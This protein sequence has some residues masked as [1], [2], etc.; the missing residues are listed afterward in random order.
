ML[1]AAARARLAET[2]TAAIV[3]AGARTSREAAFGRRVAGV[4]DPAFADLLAAPWWLRLDAAGRGRLGRLAAL[5]SLAPRLARTIDGRVL[6]TVKAAAG[7]AALDWALALGEGIAFA[8][9]LE[10][11][12]ELDRIGAGML[13]AALPEALR[14]W[15]MPDAEPADGAKAARALELAR[16]AYEALAADMPA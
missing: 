9:P 10:E 8:A 1:A 2:A 12:P 5:A 6:G 15:L 13:A 11:P 16:D 14:L 7:G 4:S 3:A